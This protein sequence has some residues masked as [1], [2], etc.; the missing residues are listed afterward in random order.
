[1]RLPASRRLLRL[2]PLALALAGAA[3]LPALAEEVTRESMGRLEETVRR[4]AEEASRKTVAVRVDD[5]EDVLGWG[6]GAVVSPEGLV[7]TCAHVSEAGGPHGRLTAVFPDGREAALAVVA[8]NSKNDL[9]L[10]RMEPALEGLPHFEVAAADAKKGDWVVA[11]GHPGGPFPDHRPTVTVGKVVEPKRRLAILFPERR[12]YEPG[13]QSDAP[14]FGGNSGGP[15]VDLEGRLAGINGAIL[16]V[17]DAAFSVPASRIR[18]ELPSLREGKDVEGDKIGLFEMI[19]E[20]QKL[21]R[22]VDPREMLAAYAD[23]GLGVILKTLGALAAASE[24]PVK[25]LG[26][27]LDDFRAAFPGV[28]GPARTGALRAKGK[29]IGFACL[30]ESKAGKARWAT[31]ARLVPAGREVAVVAP[32]ETEER[33]ARVLGRDGALDVALLETATKEGAAPVAAPSPAKDL[34]PGDFVLLPDP[35]GG[36]F[37]AG[38][39]AVADRAVGTDRRTGSFSVAGLLKDPNTAPFRPYA[40]VVQVDAPIRAEQFGGPVLRPDGSL[41]GIAVG[42]HFRAMTFVTPAPAIAARIDALAG[43]A[44]VAAPPDYDPKAVPRAKL[45]KKEGA[46]GEIEAAKK[47]LQNLRRAVEM[48]RQAK[49]T[50]PAALEE[51]TTRDT[52]SGEPFLSAVPKDP[53]GEDVDYRIVNASRGSFHLI[54]SGPDKVPG[55]ADDVVSKG[56]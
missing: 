8:S 29:P 40:S 19:G 25:L 21:S 44:D 2:L 22:E 3:P 51:L 48:H 43:G 20:M 26:R 32:G 34:R 30:W 37:Q 17:G 1:M 7:L 27:R 46:S 36:L 56:D 31:S 23:S 6:S 9:S 33:P 14:L 39:I 13:I 5:G 38:A 4:V 28:P 11:I 15:L 47:V 41:V 42:H 49:K 52:P 12:D 55:T 24:A 18:R 35:A 10:L 53:W 50:L 16:Y 54:S 45:P